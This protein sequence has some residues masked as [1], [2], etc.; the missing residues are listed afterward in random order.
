MPSKPARR[1]H[2]I[3]QF[4][5]RAFLAS[6]GTTVLVRDLATN[7]AVWRRPRSV[8]WLKDFYRVDVPGLNLDAVEGDLSKIES[9]AAEVLRK[10]DSDRALPE[11]D[12]REALMIFMA[13]MALRVP[14]FRQ[15]YTDPMTQ[16]VKDLA[17]MVTSSEERWNAFLE[18]AGERAGRLSGLSH[19]Q[20][21]EVVQK[22]EFHVEFGTTYHVEL[23][24]RQ[25]PST[26]ALLG[27]RQWSLVV[28]GAG[29]GG[30]ITSD[31]P[32]YLGW[33][34]P[35]QTFFSPGLGLQGTEV[36]FPISRQLALV[37]SWE[38]PGRVAVFD[39]RGV[40]EINNRI[41]MQAP[42]IIVSAND[43][44]DL[45][46]EDGQIVQA[47]EAFV[48]LRAAAPSNGVQMPTAD[49]PSPPDRSAR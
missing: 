14:A 24:L 19:D 3:P 21:T 16:I 43:E 27:Q 45:V 44:F 29:T 23:M 37:G 40:A 25:L 10:I 1:H 39:R 26:A 46:L 35:T 9:V 28:A 22:G 38:G 48:H 33:T 36:A 13:L 34:S 18:K 11:G 5:L 4:L 12:D 15:A 17:R 8:A 32:V 42:S 49:G 31:L 2:F 20:A 41:L 30:F 47:G 6:G 7:E